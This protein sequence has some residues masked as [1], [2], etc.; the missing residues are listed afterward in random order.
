MKKLL[1]V[2]DHA[3]LRQGIIRILKDLLEPAEFDEAQDGQQAISMFCSASYDLV[4]LDISLPDMNGLDVL[5]RLQRHNPQVPVLILSTHSDEHYAVRSLRAGAAGYLNK[6]GD[7]A[8]LKEAIET[9]LNGRR[10][11]TSAQ[12]SLIIDAVGK[13]GETPPMPDILSDRE[14]QLICMM[15]AG[16][17]LTEIAGEL[18]LSVKTVSTYRTRILEKLQLRTTADIISFGH[19]HRLA[20]RKFPA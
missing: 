19:F 16:K 5:K 15:T 14:F 12:T 20:E 17:T 4:L 18:G 2:D 8:V 1:V 10:Y 13:K 6:A 11:V 7:A 3:I 9:G